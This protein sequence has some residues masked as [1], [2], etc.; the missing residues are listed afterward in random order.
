MPDGLEA[1]V[2]ESGP[3]QV[4]WMSNRRVTLGFVPALGGRLLS[5]QLDGRELLYRNPSLLDDRLHRRAPDGLPPADGTLSSWRNYG[6]D[7]TWPAPQGWSGPAEWPGPPDPVLDSGCY[8]ADL[9]TG[10]DELRLTMVSAPDP[11]TGL[12]ISRTVTLTADA[13]E[14]PVHQWFT[15]VGRPVRWA[16]WNVL[17]L[18][19]DPSGDA[20]D[21]WYAEIDDRPDAVI[22][23]LSGNGFP[24]F[25]I[26][27]GV[28]FVPLQKV[29]GKLGLPGATGRLSTVI[30]GIEVCQ[31]FAPE[32]SADYPDRGSRAEIWLEC[33]L[34]E[35]LAHLGGLK[36]DAYVLETEVLG[37][38]TALEPGE[39][40]ELTVTI[41]ARRVDDD[42]AQTSDAH[43]G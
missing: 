17:Q 34:D 18:R 37:P 10:N 23:L 42:E 11:G 40:S 19:G 35:G 4:F 31:R 21:G 20:A 7:K 13:T 26:T 39:S 12:Q 38:L 5:F 14:F 30:D 32:I 3:D 28:V 1:H 41:S 22:E 27:D 29:V 25:S 16:I 36:P 33:P 24:R 9:E 15:C 2:D 8:Q 6:G 43:R